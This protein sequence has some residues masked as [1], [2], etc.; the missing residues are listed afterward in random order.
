MGLSQL[1]CRHDRQRTPLQD[2]DHSGND[3]RL[4]PGF[5]RQ[6]SGMFPEWFRRMVPGLCPAELLG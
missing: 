5:L 1:D 2:E 3:P 6:C 4:V